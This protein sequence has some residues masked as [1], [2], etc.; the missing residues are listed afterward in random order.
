MFV[1]DIVLGLFCFMVY[2]TVLVGLVALICLFVV[3]FG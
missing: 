1:F 2:L 3:G